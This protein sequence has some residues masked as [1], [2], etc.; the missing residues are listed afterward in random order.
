[1]VFLISGRLMFKM[2]KPPSG[3]CSLGPFH[4]ELG[5]KRKHLV[6]H[7]VLV[8]YAC[9][10]VKTHTAFLAFVSLNMRKN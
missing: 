4:V 10:V 1:M 2:P 7:C 5:M 3:L 8:F 6:L 9:A